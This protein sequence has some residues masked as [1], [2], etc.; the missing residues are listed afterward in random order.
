MPLSL[1]AATFVVTNTNDSGA[2]SFVQALVAANATSDSDTINFNIP[3]TDPGCDRDTGVCTI[4][5]SSAVGIASPVII[6][7]FTQPGAQQTGSLPGEGLKLDLKIVLHF[8]HGGPE[9]IGLY[10]AHGSDRSTLRGLVFNGLSGAGSSLLVLDRTLYNSISRNY[11]GT[12]ARGNEGD[13]NGAPRTRAEIAIRTTSSTQHNDIN[14][15]LFAG[16][17]TTGIESNDCTIRGNFFG[18]NPAGTATQHLKQAL[19][20][21]ARNVV[22]GSSPFDRNILVSDGGEFTVSSSAEGVGG[23]SMSGNY[24]GTDVTGTVAL[25]AN[26]GGVLISSPGGIL[27]RRHPSGGSGNVISGNALGAVKVAPGGSGYIADNLIGLAADGEQPLPNGFGIEVHTTPGSSPWTVS[28]AIDNNVIAFNKGAGILIAAGTGNRILGNAIYQN[29]GLGIDLGGDGPTLNDAGDTDSGANNLQNY[30]EITTVSRSDGKVTVTGMYRGAPHPYP[31]HF[32]EIFADIAADP[33]GFGEGRYL[34]GSILI[35]R[36]DAD[37]SAPFTGTFDCPADATVVS[38]TS[39]DREGNASEFSP[40]V[41]LPDAPASLENISTRAQVLRGD[42]NVIGG[43]IVGGPEPKRILV[44]AIGP[45]LAA[46]GVGNALADPAIQLFRGDT[47]IASNDDWK[48]LQQAEI[49][50]TQLPPAADAE[51]AIL[52]T[53]EPGHYTVVVRGQSGHTGI[54]LVEAYDVD[55]A[56]NAKLLNMSTRAH[57]GRGDDVMITGFIIGPVHGVRSRVLL[58]GIGPSLGSFGVADPLADPT[59]ELFDSNGVALATNDNW[60]D[61]RAAEI[62]ATTIPPA[63]DRE[64]ALLES[65]PPGHYTVILRGRADSTGAGLAEIYKLE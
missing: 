29:D 31:Y 41:P 1:T 8:E 5:L 23:N 10:L 39:M 24:I 28:A 13:S 35:L 30:P 64:A 4:R 65:L 6:D 20:L 55:R 57:V 44:R 50:A 16:R 19:R 40:A 25:G 58:R 12:D 61:G 36:T 56:A 52:G 37:G 45:S 11:F 33:S 14:G 60:R 43:F 34:L 59:L 2:G 15:N 18:T 9:A 63:D 21:V 49:E 54:A 22:G 38:A 62:A 47:P 46:R 51:S 27:L 53:L 26:C 32:V 42:R 48:E 7:G 3:L 17:T